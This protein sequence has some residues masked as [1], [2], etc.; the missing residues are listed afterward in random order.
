MPLRNWTKTTSFKLVGLYVVIF[1]ASVLVL[2]GLTYYV[3]TS[4]LDQQVRMRIEAE[5]DAL[6]GEY[7]NGGLR[8]LLGAVEERR[9]GRLRDG[10]V[11]TI[12]DSHGRRQFGTLP[13]RPSIDGWT[14]VRGPPDGDEPE[15]QTERLAVLSVRL[16]GG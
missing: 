13:S 5:S 14:E 4:A 8:Q 2:A 1:S 16:P 3:A 6:H 11:Y 9:R 7:S 15:G 12:F 10:L